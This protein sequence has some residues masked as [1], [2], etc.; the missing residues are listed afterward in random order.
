MQNLV[1]KIISLSSASERRESISTVLNANGAF[2]WIFFDALSASDPVDGL[3]VCT[4]S[5]LHSFGRIL[6]DGEIGCFKS[7]YV[8]LKNFAAQSEKKWL[9]V[10]EDDV[11]LDVRYDIVELIGYV[12]SSGIDYIR[13]CAKNYQPADVI[14]YMAGLR[15][16]VRFRTD[17]FGAQAHLINVRGAKSFLEGLSVVR[18]P[19]DDELG[20]F[21]RHHLDAYCVFPC[22]AVERVVPS[23]L[24]QDRS[25]SE[26]TRYRHKLRLVGSRVLEKCRKLAYN[27]DFVIRRRR[28]VRSEVDRTI[29]RLNNLNRTS[30]TRD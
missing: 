12:E 13:L 17:P 16:I 8:V 9:L 20:R 26:R 21:W 18:R 23:S 4:R 7:H 1:V 19:V 22:P 25:E 24:E 28:R 14:A 29:V 3:A 11:W 30:A 2:R 10:L 6:N 15:Q 5:Q 27:S